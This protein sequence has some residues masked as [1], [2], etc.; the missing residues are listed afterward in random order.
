MSIHHTHK[1]YVYNGVHYCI[2]CGCYATNQLKKLASECGARAVAGQRF[3][4]ELNM[5]HLPESANINALPPNTLTNIEQDTLTVVQNGL[6]LIENIVQIVH[7]SE[8]ETLYSPQS[9]L[10]GCDSDS[11]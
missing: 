1:P 9:P 2:K 11:D 5:G 8:E 10:V 3:L 6:D 7:E 4:N